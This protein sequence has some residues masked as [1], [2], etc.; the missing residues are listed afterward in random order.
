MTYLSLPRL[1]ELSD[2]L[3][4][5]RTMKRAADGFERALYV[6]PLKWDEVDAVVKELIA[7]RKGEVK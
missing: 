5:K 1:R 3:A 4:D 2:E 7:R 6:S